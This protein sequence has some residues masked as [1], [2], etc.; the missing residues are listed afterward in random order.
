MH[1]F[2]HELFHSWGIS[3]EVGDVLSG[4]VEN[5]L[6]TIPILFLAYL[7]M[8]YIEHKASSK[9]EGAVAKIGKFG[10]FVGT[11]LGLIPQ[12]GFSASCSNLYAASLLTEGTLIAVFIA[13]SDEAIPLLLADSRVAGDIWKF[14]LVKI[15]FGI[16]IG[17]GV[18]LMLRIL[19]IKKKPIEMC[20]DCG[21][22]EE[23]GILK[24]AL[25]HTLKTG[26][27]ILILSVAIDII[28]MLVGT[29]NL[30]AMLGSNNI[31]QPFL[32]ALLGL[33]PNCSVSIALIEL[34]AEGILSFG[35]TCAGLCSGAGIGIAV[36]FKANKSLK[37]NLRIVGILYFAS[38]FIG[39]FLMLFG[40]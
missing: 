33:I 34:Y 32:T 13:T 4:I 3:H 36:L 31:F 24:S 21:C 25:K 9:M 26:A 23:N 15:A 6:I 7:L 27:F 1:E 11:G 37:E 39:F 18:D 10:P 16:I 38:A 35:S 29:E 30:K 14:L 40:A 19:K 17:F 8:E 22:E 20:K 28:M 5:L 2:F 12:C